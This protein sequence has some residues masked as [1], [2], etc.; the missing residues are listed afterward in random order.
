MDIAPNVPDRICLDAEGGIWSADPRNN[1]V[2]RVLEGGKIT[3][4]LSTGERGAYAC[5][6]G[7][8]ARRRLYGISLEP[9]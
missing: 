4:R 3:A 8:V 7:G 9:V 5:M 6:L 1:E 2:I